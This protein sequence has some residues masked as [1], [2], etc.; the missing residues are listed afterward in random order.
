[1]ASACSVHTFRHLVE[2]L[3]HSS[4]WGK[5]HMESLQLL[6]PAYFS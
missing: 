2:E 6:D 5:E 4:D 1:M 3:G